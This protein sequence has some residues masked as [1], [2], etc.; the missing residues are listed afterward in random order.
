[1]NKLGLILL[2]ASTAVIVPVGATTITLQAPAAPNGSFD[3]LVNAAGVFDVPH[4]ADFLLAYGFDVIFDPL[5]LT[6]LGETAGSLF[7]DLSGN[8][9]IGADVAGVATAILLGPGDFTEPLTLAVLHFGLVGSGP[10]SISITGD[11]ANPD[12]GLVYL[13]GSDAISAS[14]RVTATATPE[15]GAVLLVGLGLFAIGIMS[16]CNLNYADRSRK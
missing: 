12:Q 9:G 2:L 13:S 1:M 6:Y 8:P 5:V 11:P 4:D 14:T 15:P 7:D 10:T 16:K 3:V